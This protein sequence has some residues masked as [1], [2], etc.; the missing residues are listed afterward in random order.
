MHGEPRAG[1]RVVPF[2]INCELLREFD[3]LI[4]PFQRSRELEKLVRAKVL[5]DK[6]GKHV[7]TLALRDVLALID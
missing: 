7:P 6:L 1:C 4:E 5:K 3:A 2:T